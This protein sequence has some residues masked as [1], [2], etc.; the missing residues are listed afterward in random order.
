MQAITHTVHVRI[1]KE[2]WG[3]PWAFFEKFK[4]FWFTLWDRGTQRW[5]NGSFWA[6]HDW[7]PCIRS[8]RFPLLPST[9]VYVKKECMLHHWLSLPVFAAISI[10]GYPLRKRSCWSSSLLFYEWLVQTCGQGLR[11]FLISQYH[12]EAQL[13]NWRVSMTLISKFI[14]L[15][16]ES[17][18]CT[19]PSWLRATLH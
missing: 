3:L 18:T 7:K 12:W 8:A 11:Y 10:W 16:Y 2:F 13:Q 4:H 19:V 9:K 5:W 15:I 17:P 6:N 14:A 1:L